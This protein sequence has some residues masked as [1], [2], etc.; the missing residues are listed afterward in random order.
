MNP[1]YNSMGG[2]PGIA[3][4]LRDLKANPLGMISRRFNLPAGMTSDPNAI[5]QYLMSTGQVS[6]GSIN[7]AYNAARNIGLR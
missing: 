6:Q 3:Q 7:A 5:L 1:F 2:Q 4:A